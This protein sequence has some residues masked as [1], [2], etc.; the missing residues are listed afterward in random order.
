MF[1]D[2]H[3]TDVAIVGAGIAGVVAAI[4]ALGRGRRVVLLDRDLE[5]NLGGQA[6]EAFGG[7]WFAGTPLQRRRG[8]KDS[9]ELGLSDW[10]AFGE[11]TTEDAWPCAW[12]RAYVERSVPEVHD[13]LAALG[14]RFMPMPMWV[15]R[16]LY[17]PGNSVPRFHLVW[18]T[19]RALSDCLVGRLLEHPRRDLLE[20]RF[21]H[22]V[23]ALVSRAGRIAGVRGTVEPGGEAFEIAS[24][25][26][27]I[28]AGGISGDIERV[29]RHWQ[30]DW[31][32]TAARDPE[33]L[34]SLCRRP[35]GPTRLPP[36]APPS[37][38]L[39]GNGITRPASATGGRA[40]PATGFR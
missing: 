22:R 5:E 25:S 33:R 16:G 8:I 17:V 34:A 32:R 39:T 11:L 13:W 10:L 24:E 28:A 15:E 12:A 27:V 35:A 31:R 36:W 1:P 20:L 14:I 38:T 29:R 40:S 7:L 2:R 21:A 18:G 3:S 26:V 4:E 19:G 23:D 6:K 9:A 30:A 37:R